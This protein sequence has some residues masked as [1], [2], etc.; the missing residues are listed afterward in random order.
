MMIPLPVIT[1]GVSLLTLINKTV[2]QYFSS[3][4]NRLKVGLKYGIFII[5]NKN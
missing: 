3:V 5:L 1:L 4:K 2:F